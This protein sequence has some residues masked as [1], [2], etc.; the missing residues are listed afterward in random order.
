MNMC[1][2]IY[3]HTRPRVRLCVY[4]CM[5]MYSYMNI[6]M[7]MRV[8]VHSQT[9]LCMHSQISLCTHIF[10]GV[11]EWSEKDTYICTLLAEHIHIFYTRTLNDPPT[12]KYIIVQWSG[13]RG[14]NT[15]I[16]CYQN[17]YINPC[18]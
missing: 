16:L 9:S 6:H 10:P 12:Y 2:Y 8:Y 15:H 1:I 13:G 4:T 3:M 7:Y 14:T 5:Y 18:A 17:T 11:M